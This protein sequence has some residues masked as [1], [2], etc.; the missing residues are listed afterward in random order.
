MPKIKLHPKNIPGLSTDK[1]QED[2][3]DTNT[4]GF[5]V[6]VSKT[7]TK[8]FQVRYR[9]KGSRTYK[10]QALGRTDVFTLKEARQR[11]K[12][13]LGAVADG[14]DP[15]V[16]RVSTTDDSFEYASIRWEEEKQYCPCCRQQ[17]LWAI[18]Y[19]PECDKDKA[20]CACSCLLPEYVWARRKKASSVAAPSD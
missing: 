18:Q 10:R 5:G 3:W 13:W 9:P 7:G 1:A 2:F 8:T 14:D 15:S 6:R 17:Q 12:E 11:A 16:S 20:C 4:T 19:H